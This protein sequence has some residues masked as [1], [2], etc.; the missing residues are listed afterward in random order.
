MCRLT[1]RPALSLSEHYFCHVST[2]R[3]KNVTFKYT[4]KSLPFCFCNWA[5]Y[6]CFAI[7]LKTK[8]SLLLLK[9]RVR[10]R[11]FISSLRSE[12]PAIFDPVDM[13]VEVE[14]VFFVHGFI[15]TKSY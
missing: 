10:D 4:S 1:E 8:Y 5:K 7:D 9:L 11:E 13:I 2:I 6:S 14:I 3:I 15:Y 12:L